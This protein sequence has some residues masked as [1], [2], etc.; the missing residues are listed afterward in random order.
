MCQFSQIYN[1]IMALGYCQLFVS[2]QY[3]KNRLMDLTKF[4][5]GIDFDQIYV[6]IVMRQF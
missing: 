4:C 5:M 2:A 3:L 1:T 6:R